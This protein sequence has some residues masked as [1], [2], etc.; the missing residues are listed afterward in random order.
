[1]RE[2]NYAKGNVKKKENT[3]LSHKRITGI[4]REERGKESG[5]VEIRKSHRPQR[6]RPNVPFL[7]GRLRSSES[8][9]IKKNDR[10]SYRRCRRRG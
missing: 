7:L 5:A 10:G 1:M 8:R 6:G 9:G 2:D 3:E 4:H